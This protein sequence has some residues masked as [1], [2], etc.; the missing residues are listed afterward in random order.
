V[1]LSHAY[2][3]EGIAEVVLYVNG[4]AHSRGTPGEPGTDFSEFTHE[5][6]P[7]G[8]G[9]Y[10]IQLWVYDSLGETGDPATIAVHVGGD[11]IEPP[12][13]TSPP[14]A[15][16][17]DTPTPTDVPTAT[18]PPPRPTNTSTSPP[19]APKKDTTAPPVPTPAVP[20]DGLAVSCRS[21]QTLAWTPVQDDNSGIM[22]YD[23]IL[24]R[25][26]TAGNWQEVKSWNLVSGKQVTAT[27]DCGIKYRWR[28]RA[29]D[30]A[31]NYSAW[32]AYSR[33]AIDLT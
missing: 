7:T 9:D 28:V 11:E 30:N 29:R 24:Q 8:P 18:N 15:T 27:V 2:A 6:A 1:V 23:V 33:F 5:W 20:A 4:V 12:T 3:R 13:P 19:P 31:G 32:S 26:V 25:E 17:V 16:F 22:G 21:S 10:T 14:T